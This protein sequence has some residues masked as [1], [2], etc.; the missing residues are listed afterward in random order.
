MVALKQAIAQVAARID[1]DLP[2]GPSHSNIRFKLREILTRDISD[3]GDIGNKYGPSLVRAYS[4]TVN[5]T[6][7]ITPM[8]ALSRTLVDMVRTERDGEAIHIDAELVPYIIQII[9][10]HYQSRRLND[11]LDRHPIQVSGEPHSLSLRDNSRAR[12]TR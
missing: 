7:T 5:S 4:R 3:A 6:S 9:L 12:T 2:E 8:D 10:G 11:E 1:L